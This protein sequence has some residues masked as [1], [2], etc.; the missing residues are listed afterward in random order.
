MRKG[1]GASSGEAIIVFTQT[2]SPLHAFFVASC[3]Q[4]L[5]GMSQGGLVED[6]CMLMSAVIEGHAGNANAAGAKASANDSARL[7][8][9]FAMVRAS[10]ISVKPITPRPP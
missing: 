2:Q 5:H 6:A 8:V 10:A 4:P 9:Q 7:K 3:E 1:T